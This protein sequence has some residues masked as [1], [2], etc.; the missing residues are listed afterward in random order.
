MTEILN[1]SVAPRRSGTTLLTVLA[2]AALLLAA[3]GLYGVLS[4]SVAQ[5]VREIGIRMALGARP[6][7]LLA[8]I[9]GRGLGM[10]LVGVILGLA[11]AF[12]LT[13]L[14]EHLLYGISATDPLTFISIAVLLTAVASMACYLPARRASRLNPTVALRY[15]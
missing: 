11:G 8:M 12:V 10:T 2:G 9:V 5:R 6:E 14:M 1:R 7:N 3:I 15:D 4:Y 13:R